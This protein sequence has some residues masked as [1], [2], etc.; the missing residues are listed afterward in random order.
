MQTPGKRPRDMTLEEKVLHYRQLR[1]QSH[2]RETA[3]KRWW[4][5]KKDR[6]RKREKRAKKKL[7]LASNSD[8]PAQH[9]SEQ[10]CSPV[11]KSE[12]NLLSSIRSKLKS[13][14]PGK[15]ARMLKNL[16]TKK[17]SSARA[18]AIHHEGLLGPHSQQML[19]KQLDL[20]RKKF[21]T[22]GKRKKRVDGLTEDTKALIRNFFFRE[23]VS[24]PLPS[25]R[26]ATKHGAGYV[27]Q[28]TLRQA[29]QL[30]R[31]EHPDVKVGYTRFTLL[32][33]KNVRKIS[34]TF[35]DTCQCVYCL[36]VRLKLLAINRCISR[37]GLD[38]SLKLEDE[39]SI[40]G[41]LLCA[42]QP[43][44]PF[45]APDCI[46]GTCSQCCKQQDTIEQ[47]FQPLLVANP[48]ICWSKWD[49][50][51]GGREPVVCTGTA[52]QLMDELITDVV[53]PCRN[54]SFVQHLFTAHWQHH[55]YRT[56]KEKLIIGQ[57]LVVMDF[58]ENKKKR[59]PG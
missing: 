22:K 19:Q 43:G 42:K 39:R 17:V 26:H 23:D 36:N 6:E 50:A 33:P 28:Q 32:R 8:Q 25:K 45:H 49:R 31:V 21:L 11:K 30:F 47:H 38:A 1:Q 54:S 56:L 35:L 24:R 18:K 27:L 15:F 48:T 40:A 46:N 59:I 44:D 51:V 12:F 53:A 3:K 7:H 57:V 14:T 20:V 5:L 34:A 9:Q 52:R 58:A 55:Q 16:A 10:F 29:H 41:L 13:K 4:R 37:S 2:Q